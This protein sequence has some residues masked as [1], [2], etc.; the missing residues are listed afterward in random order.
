[1][2]LHDQNFV[3]FVLEETTCVFKTKQSP[4]SRTCFSHASESCFSHAIQ[5][6]TCGLR[7]PELEL[8]TEHGTLGGKFTTVE[9]LLGDIRDQLSRRNPF[10]AGDSAQT[11]TR[12]KLARFCA[13]LEKVRGVILL[14]RICRESLPTFTVGVFQILLGVAA[15]VRTPAP[16]MLNRK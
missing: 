7:I 8:E 11:G 9:G 10:F 3:Q 14:E 6:E 2:G 16:E 5:S 1:M 4:R 15:L 12:D 13:D